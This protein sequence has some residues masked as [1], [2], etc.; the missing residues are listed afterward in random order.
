MDIFVEAT[1]FTC[2][3]Y[4]WMSFSKLFIFFFSDVGSLASAHLTFL[5]DERTWL[6]SIWFRGGGGQVI[7]QVNAKL[8]FAAEAGSCHTRLLQGSG[9][10]RKPPDKGCAGEGMSAL[11]SACRR[12][13][14]GSNLGRPASP[15][16][17]RGRGRQRGH[18][19]G[20]A[21]RRHSSPITVNTNA[22][23][24]VF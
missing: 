12:G 4:F 6:R 17:A 18:P 23:H 9:D 1:L 14:A 3:F 8:A 7:V 10:P 2:L 19:L 16:A 24:H 21:A 20:G 15:R 22:L 5:S 13:E 11:F